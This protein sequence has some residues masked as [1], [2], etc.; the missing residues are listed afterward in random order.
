MI[1]LRQ[2][3]YF[4][5]ILEQGS[6]SSAAK[7]V[8]VAQP[9]LSQHVRKMEQALGTTL[10]LRGAKGV[11]PTESGEMFASRARTILADAE[12]AE[13]EIRS[14]GKVPVGTVRLGLPGTISDILSVP[15][16][17]RCLDRYPGIKIIIAEAMSGFVREWLM[18]RNLELAVIYSDLREVGMT[19]EALLEEELVLLMPPDHGQ[20]GS[21][22]LEFL[23]DRTLILPSKAHGLRVMLDKVFAAQGFKLAPTIELD[24]YR[25]IKQLVEDG[26]GCSILPFH[27]VEAELGSG[28]LSVH[29]FSDIALKRGAYLIQD[30]SRPTTR[31]TAVLSQLIREVV[32]ELILEGKWSGA[33]FPEAEK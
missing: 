3:R 26:Y 33:R 19:S 17:T 5:A 2:M 12:Q 23:S 21:L 22:G 1:D 32:D 20:R 24:S 13:E 31:A 18:T 11:V 8:N 6:F 14:Y 10:L 25:N 29:H 15:L 30:V 4:L 7:T 9:A 16:I 28:K 27:A